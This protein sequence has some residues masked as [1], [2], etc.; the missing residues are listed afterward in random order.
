[1]ENEVK[2]SASKVWLIPTIVAAVLLIGLVVFMVIMGKGTSALADGT[3][4]LSEAVAPMQDGTAQLSEGVD[5]YTDGVDQVADGIEQLND[6]A[7]SLVEGVNLLDQT[8][9]AGL[10][11][12]QKADTIKAV[13]KSINDSFANPNNEN[14]TAQLTAK[15][16]KG[17]RDM[18]NSGKGDV[19]K[20]LL[21]NEDLVN[22]IKLG[23][24]AQ[25]RAT[26]EQTVLTVA[27][28]GL[29]QMGQ[30]PVDKATLLT[31]WN[32]PVQALAPTFPD[33][34]TKVGEFL[35]SNINTAMAASIP[36]SLTYDQLVDALYA[37][38]V[39]V[40]ATTTAIITNVG[41]GVVDGIAN[42]A[43][44][45][46]GALIAE[47]TRQGAL[48][49]GREVAITVANQTMA[50]VREGIKPLVEGAPQ[51]TDGIK[52]LFDGSQ[53]LKE[54]SQALRDGASQLKDAAPALIDG[55]NQLKDGA[56]KVNGFTPIH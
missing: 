5:A 17:V 23:V 50:N 25:G 38:K 49:A 27:N 39:D 40:D 6:A 41:N 28:A 34:T 44:P 46:A 35:I 24:A 19:V 8:L 47:A 3:V 55:I 16:D 20:T 33:A 53:Q 13:E 30:N 29:A 26:I 12:K 11:E 45:A 43:A 4:T 36:V 15:A 7:P 54:N 21:A 14:G 32:Y 48:S 18:L 51:L 37:A 2:K 56:K 52:Q 10:T 9:K 1:M 42:Q 22:V 31:I